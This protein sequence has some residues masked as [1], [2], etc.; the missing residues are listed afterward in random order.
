MIEYLN[1]KVVKNDGLYEGTYEEEY[2]KAASF[3]AKHDYL[4]EKGTVG[5]EMGEE[6]V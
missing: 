3:R 5:D 2:A 1:E 6:G 4:D